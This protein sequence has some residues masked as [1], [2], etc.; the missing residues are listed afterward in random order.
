MSVCT[1][2]FMCVKCVSLRV[3]LYMF[4]D[5]VCICVFL[6]VCVCVSV[7]VCPCALVSVCL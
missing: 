6:C 1:W 7:S 5:G 3:V 4:S 2:L